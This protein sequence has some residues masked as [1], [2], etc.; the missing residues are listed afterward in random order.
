MTRAL[1][2]ALA[3]LAFPAMAQQRMPCAPRSA[4]VSGLTE[5]KERVVLRGIANDNMIEVWLSDEGGFSIILTR[6]EGGLSCMLSAG[7]SMH[8]V[9][10]P[11]PKSG[12]KS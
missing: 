7:A 5:Y 9:G 6:A 12:P 4:V 11:T 1:A 10:Q 8:A 2:I 3:L